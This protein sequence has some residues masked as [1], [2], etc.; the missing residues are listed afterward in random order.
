MQ[1][2]WIAKVSP[3]ADGMLL[4]DY[5]D[6][7][8]IGTDNLFDHFDAKAKKKKDFDIRPLVR[9]EVRWF[10]GKPDPTD[11]GDPVE[12]INIVREAVGMKPFDPKKLTKQNAPIEFLKG[13]GYI[14]REYQ[15][16]DLDTFYDWKVAPFNRFKGRKD[17]AIYVVSFGS[18]R[19][20]DQLKSTL[21]ER[22]EVLSVS[23]GL[24]GRVPGTRSRTIIIKA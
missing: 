13:K 20:L 5:P 14:I 22:F 4:W 8:L 23:K 10:V 7:G 11:Q 16:E 3:D 21:G 2:P 1:K 17:I 6:K 18:I 9:E 12:A 19:R 15:R 24:Y